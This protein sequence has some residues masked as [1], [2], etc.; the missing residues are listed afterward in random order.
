MNELI[1]VLIADDHDVVREGLSSLIKAEPDLQLVG[2]AADGVE[3]VDKALRLRPAVILMDL[4]M[5]RLGG[6][7]AISQIKQAW[8][9]ARILVLTSFS[10]DNKMLPA[11]KAGAQGYLLKNAPAESIIQAI[12][13]LAHDRGV[14]DPILARRLMREFD[15]TN[16]PATPEPTLTPRETEILQLIAHGLSNQ[17]IADRLCLSEP[18]VRVQV[19]HILSALQVSNRTQAALYALRKGI[20]SLEPPP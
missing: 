17:E 19:S 4:M 10:D 5:P 16:A 7:E 9:E 12:R 20:A 14:L 8:P 3:A 13:D 11:L 6:L 15:Q 2:E 18:T 1:R